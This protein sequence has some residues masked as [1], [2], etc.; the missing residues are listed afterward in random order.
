MSIYFP[1]TSNGSWWV[2]FGT[3][4]AFEYIYRHCSDKNP[5]DG[6]QKVCDEKN[7]IVERIKQEQKSLPRYE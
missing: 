1:Q 3:K 2:C 4:V 5:V 6:V 7:K